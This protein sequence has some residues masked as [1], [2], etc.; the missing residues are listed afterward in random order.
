MNM[1]T[2]RYPDTFSA[3]RDL[4]VSFSEDDPNENTLF[5]QDCFEPRLRNFSLLEKVPEEFELVTMPE[6]VAMFTMVAVKGM[7]RRQ[8][9][10][11]HLRNFGAATLSEL[12]RLM[13]KKAFTDEQLSVGIVAPS[14]WVRQ[15]E[16][17]HIGFTAWIK[18]VPGIKLKDGLGL[19]FPR[20]TE[21]MREYILLVPR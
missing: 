5:P 8:M 6:Y 2:E 11:V 19:Y 16:P 18:R 13:E 7:K 14:T 15:V 10:F 4:G 3:L 1:L 21:F 20:Y 9:Q 17:F 12:T